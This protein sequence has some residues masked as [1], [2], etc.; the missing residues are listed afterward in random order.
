[1]PTN[2]TFLLFWIFCLKYWSLIDMTPKRQP[3]KKWIRGINGFRVVSLAS[4]RPMVKFSFYF[5]STKLSFFEPKLV[6]NSIF[7]IRYEKN[8]N[9]IRFLMGDLGRKDNKINMSEKPISQKNE[10]SDYLSVGPL[11]RQKKFSF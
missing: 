3:F 9:C 2:Q 6:K 1:M 7:P 5:E 10:G 11:W 4:C 8:I